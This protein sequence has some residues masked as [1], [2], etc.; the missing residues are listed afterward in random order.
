M[1]TNMIKNTVFNQFIVDGNNIRDFQKE[2][3]YVG[4]I[5]HLKNEEG[6]V[7]INR[8]L[9]FAAMSNSDMRGS[10]IRAMSRR[11][12]MPEEKNIELQQEIR[13]AIE[14][15]QEN[16]MNPTLYKGFDHVIETL[17]QNRLIVNS[18]AY[19]LSS[20]TEHYDQVIE[21]YEKDLMTYI[22]ESKEVEELYKE[23]DKIDAIA[24][25]FD[26]EMK[27]SQL[28]VAHGMKIIEETKIKS[29]LLEFI[30]QDTSDEVL[31]ENAG[32]LVHQIAQYDDIVTEAKSLS[33]KVKDMTLNAEKKSRRMASSIKDKG[34][35][36]KRIAVAGGKTIKHFTSITN[37]LA[38]D[39]ENF[40]ID[41][42]KETLI[43]NSLI[44]RLKKLIRYTILNISVLGV[45]G[46]GPVGITTL[47]SSYIVIA[48]I[49]N[50]TDDKVL[51][52][53][54]NDLELELKMTKEK[55]READN[56]GDTKAK[57]QLMRLQDGIERD[58]DRLNKGGRDRSRSQ[59][60]RQNGGAT[61]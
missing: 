61:V 5:K 16:N 45:M 58:I 38:Q 49:K 44:T 51:R 23:Q 60:R 21:T 2:M 6:F 30:Y 11:F 53:L 35:K 3:D 10:F 14:F 56:N 34:A 19:L 37:K 13:H 25:G 48:V 29:A 27:E 42:R 12:H 57:Y 32:R 33:D 36:S 9:V 47:L 40:V 15:V 50:K 22:T 59:V 24:D 20:M 52:E 26:K 43:D 4:T 54:K 39:I 31:L 1:D 28:K 18:N 46:S 17:E 41:K 55:I 8:Q 7:P